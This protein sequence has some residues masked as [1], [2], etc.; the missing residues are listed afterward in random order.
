MKDKQVRARYTP[1][2]KLEAVRHVHAG[3]ASA[4]RRVGFEHHP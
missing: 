3:Q 1:E 4:C 2:F